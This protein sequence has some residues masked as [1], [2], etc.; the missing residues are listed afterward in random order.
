MNKNCKVLDIVKNK[1][2]ETDP[3][4]KILIKKYKDAVYFG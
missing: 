3:M 1:E 4:K 2:Y